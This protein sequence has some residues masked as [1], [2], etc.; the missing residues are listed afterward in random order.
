MIKQTARYQ[1]WQILVKV[2]EQKKYSNL[3]LNDLVR[4]NLDVKSKNFVFA[5]VHGTIKNKMFLDYLTKTLID[6]RKT[7][8]NLQ[9]LL[10]MSLYQIHFMDRTQNYAIVNEAVEIAKTFVEPRVAGVVNASLKKVL[11][12][13]DFFM[14]KFNDSEKQLCLLHS[15]PFELFKKLKHD[16]GLEIATKIVEDSLQKP[17]ISFRVNTLKIPTQKFYEIYQEQYQLEKG[18]S[19]DGL[20]AHLPVVHTPIYEQ[21]LIT[22][23]DQASILVG[24]IAHVKP[25]SHVLDMCSAPGGKLTHL[26]ALMGDTKNLIGNEINLYKIGL[27]EENIQRLG[28]KNITLKNQDARKFAEKEFFDAI[29]LDA[30]CS[31]FGVFKRKPEIKLHYNTINLKSLVELQKELLDI[32]YFNL[33]PGGE[34]TYSTCTFNQDECANQIKSFLHHY[35]D[36]EIIL[37]K[38][39]FGFEKNTDGF[40][41]CKL[42]K[43]IINS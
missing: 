43:L 37:E 35:P 19:Q 12:T 34:L 33:K 21:G 15:F 27:I 28:I 13:D 7:P 25:N 38:Q 10:W 40:Y 23:Q 32:A 41:I 22:I 5:L 30:P 39:I 9:V 36:M 29:I 17:N 26:A 31:G 3:L 14:I 6:F 42:K 20:I 1:A 24:E 11:A 4:T 8:F 2:F 18:I 16:Y